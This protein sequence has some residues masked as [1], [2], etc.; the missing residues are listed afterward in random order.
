MDA[1]TAWALSASKWILTVLA[2]WILLRCVRSMLRER[3]EPEIW[4]YLESPD[5]SRAALKHWC[6]IIGRSKS[7]DVTVNRRSVGRTHAVLLRSDKGDWRALR[8]PQRRRDRRSA[9]CGRWA[10]DSRSATGYTLFFADAG[11]TFTTSGGRE[12]TAE[13]EEARTAPGARVGQGVTLLLLTVFQALSRCSSRCSQRP[14]SDSTRP[15][16]SPARRRGVVCL[17]FIMRAFRRSGFEPE[18][19]AFI[20][21]FA[22][23]LRLRDQRAGRHA[24]A[25]R[26]LLIAG[27]AAYLLLGWWLRDLHP[28]Q[29]GALAV[30]PGR[31][32]PP[33]AQRGRR[34]GQ[35][36][37]DELA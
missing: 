19:L 11:M 27:I 13:N 30:R 2:L 8:S 24:Q 23:T 12:L 10:G 32:R 35:L 29:G 16:A 28:Y 4:G 3:Y 6:C 33:R 1:L 25:A 17:Y 22:G 7:C 18:T 37:R 5:G 9:R 15:W 34:A 26:V 21:L 14:G 20:P 31:A 36:R